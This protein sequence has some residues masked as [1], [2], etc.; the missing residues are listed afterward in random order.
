MHSI[1]GTGIHS[2]R[3]SFIELNDNFQKAHELKGH[4]EK[5][6]TFSGTSCSYLISSLRDSLMEKLARWGVSLGRKQELLLVLT[7]TDRPLNSYEFS[8]L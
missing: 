7:F 6:K 8:K 2:K 5:L 1:L 4:L 3:A